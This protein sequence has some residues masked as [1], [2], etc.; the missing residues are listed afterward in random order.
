MAV[1]IT[2]VILTAVCT[3]IGISIGNGL[4][5]IYFKD[6]LKK[7]KK[8]NER[9]KKLQEDRFKRLCTK[10][11][12]YKHPWLA[13][14]LNIFFWGTGYFYVKRKKFLG[15]VLLLVQ[16]FIIGGYI[17]SMNTIAGVFEGFSYSFLMLII[18]IYLGVDAYK[19][20]RQVN[21]GTD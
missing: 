12:V 14:L 16:M 3:G 13:A 9:L 18:S 7:L 1:D 17:F 5:D 6:S 4:Y 20:A 8:Q 15:A 11:F 2:T 10:L 21:A 19:L